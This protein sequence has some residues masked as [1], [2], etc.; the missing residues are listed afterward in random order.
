MQGKAVLHRDT[1]Q[2]S[3]ELTQRKKS[4]PWNQIKT[5]VLTQAAGILNAKKQVHFYCVQAALHQCYEHK[6]SSI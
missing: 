6:S 4:L 3:L 5:L 2:V 1:I